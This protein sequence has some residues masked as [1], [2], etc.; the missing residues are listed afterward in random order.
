MAGKI[1]QRFISLARTGVVAGLLAVG[2]L[3]ANGTANAL[4][5]E[6]S[7]APIIPTPPIVLEGQDGELDQT[8]GINDD[9]GIDGITRTNAGLKTE[10]FSLIFSLIIDHEAM[11]QTD[12]KILRLT[13]QASDDEVVDYLSLIFPNSLQRLNYDGTIDNSF[14]QDGLLLGADLLGFPTVLT[15]FSVQNDGKIL[16]TG[17]SMNLETQSSFLLRILSDGT[18]DRSFGNNGLI[19]FND[20]A[21]SNLWGFNIMVQ[22]D[23]S[24]ILS[25]INQGDDQSQFVMI[26]FDANGL[27]DNTFADSGTFLDE[28][29]GNIA[30]NN[31]VFQQSD[32]KLI[33]IRQETGDIEDTLT[34]STVRLT[35]DGFVDNSY[36][37]DGVAT[38]LQNSSS[39][40]FKAAMQPD[41]QIVLSQSSGFGSVTSFVRISADGTLDQSFTT[42]TELS[43]GDELA[44]TGIFD[45]AVQPDGKIVTTG[46]KAAVAN[47]TLSEE[48][49]AT[50][51]TVLAELVSHRFLNDGSLDN[52]FGD[53]GVVAV[54]FG[55]WIA[56]QN[57]IIQPNG[58][59]LILGTGLDFTESDLSDIT[60]FDIALR[61]NSAIPVSVNGVTPSRLFDTRVGSPQG[62]IVVDKTT[63]GGSKELRVKVSGVSGLPEYG[64]GAATINLTVTDPDDTGYITVYPCGTRPLASNMNYVA[65][66][67]VST[68]VTTAVSPTGEICVYSSAQTNLIADINS[69]SATNA[70]YAPLSPQRLVDTRAR[71]PQGAITVVKKKYGADSEL[72]VKVAGAAG[73]PGARMSSVSLNVT[74]TE[75][76]AEGFLTVYPC[77]TRPLASHLNFVADQTISASVTSP[78]S[79]D[80]EI[81]IYSSS[82]TNLI[83]DT[84]GWFVQ[85]SGITPVGPTRLVDTRSASPQGAISVTQK[86]YGAT[87]ELRLPL[88]NVAGL[89]DDGIGTVQLTVTATNPSD[90]GFITVYPCGTLPLASHLNY[91]TG[92][93]I[94]A[95]VT[96]QVSTDG[97]I[98]V[99]SNQPTNIIIDINGWGNQP[100]EPPVVT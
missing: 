55:R 21:L 81:C 84:F 58:Q 97:E 90:T 92:Q 95:S 50:D 25:G 12:G 5:L 45:V 43:I 88:N 82:P 16:I 53:G 31:N 46:I 26:R 33:F 8:F 37:I 98:C 73:L 47:P 71:S 70:G 54:E 38:F 62:T 89:P 65:D 56:G 52:T 39:N 13:T 9:D 29:A 23:G 77:G 14:A 22:N 78:V 66:Q 3:T 44:N 35:A 6:P 30:F 83:A 67:T 99:H 48:E 2:L 10:I 64:I 51:P 28:S 100:Q 75:P 87:D 59:I 15:D 1:S 91:T 93:T 79:A 69:W 76:E 42:N 85:G 11:Q 4:Q 49:P 86:K 74:V 18:L 63:Y 27:K 32:G 24:L 19:Q 72:R 57:V 94:A 68:S 60:S 40:I 61:L 20:L 80:G 36:G 41:N 7:G 96:T 34:S 17:L